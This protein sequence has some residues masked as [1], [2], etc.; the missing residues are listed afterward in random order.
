MAPTLTYSPANTATQIRDMVRLL[1]HD[2][3][4]DR[5]LL[6]DAEVDAFIVMRGRLATGEDPQTYP[7]AVYQIAADCCDA[8]Q[9]KYASESESVLTDVGVVRSTAA[10]EYAKLGA[11]FRKM[12]EG[13]GTLAFVN[14]SDYKTTFVSGV[15]TLPLPE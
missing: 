14:P 5:P 9:A 8:I 4:S 10:G 11:K 7:S 6:D 15:D 13:S 12:G 2:V 3:H 1:V